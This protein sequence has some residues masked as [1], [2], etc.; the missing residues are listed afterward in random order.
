[1]IPRTWAEIL[2]NSAESIETLVKDIPWVRESLVNLYWEV[3]LSQAEAEALREGTL[4]E[5]KLAELYEVQ[6]AQRDALASELSE[7]AASQA[8]LWEAISASD[9]ES[10]TAQAEAAD[11]I[12]AIDEWDDTLVWNNG[13]DTIAR[14]ASGSWI[15][16]DVVTEIREDI[17]S[18]FDIIN[19]AEEH[20]LLWALLKG[21]F[22]VL[23][24]LGFNNPFDVKDEIVEAADT[25]VDDS[26]MRDE[27]GE[28]LQTAWE[29]PERLRTHPALQEKLNSLL[30][31][32]NIITAE[33][34][35]AIH[36]AANWGEIDISVIKWAL[37]VETYERLISGILEDSEMSLIIK[38][39]IISEVSESVMDAYPHIN[40]RPESRDQLQII[41]REHLWDNSAQQLA[42]DFLSWEKVG[43]W[44]LLASAPRYAL[45]ATWLMISLVASWVI[46]ISDIALDI[47][48]D[49]VNFTF[50]ATGLI[51][52]GISIP[53][54]DFTE[55]LEE[56]ENVERW[57][58]LAVMYRQSGPFVRLISNVMWWLTR[59]IIDWL[60]TNSLDINKWDLA[61]WNA[62]SKL[63]NFTKLSQAVS[64][65]EWAKIGDAVSNGV[66]VLRKNYQIQAIMESGE[67]IQNLTAQLNALDPDILG[68]NVATT[69]DDLRSIVK[70]K[71]LI[72]SEEVFD[73]SRHLSGYLPGI[74][75]AEDTLT[76]S[77]QNIAQYQKARVGRNTIAQIW[78][79]PSGLLDELR[80]AQRGERLV[81]EGLDQAGALNK[82]QQLK[83]LATEFPDVFRHTLGVFPE[84]AFLWLD[85]T[86]RDDDTSIL[87]SIRDSLI[88]MTGIIWPIKLV[89]SGGAQLKEWELQWY[90]FAAA[91]A[92]TVL[93]AMDAINVWRIASQ[94][95]WAANIT[96][97]IWKEVVLRPISNV[98]N[99]G[100]HIWKFWRWIWRVALGTGTIDWAS[101]SRSIR[102]AKIPK[103]W[104][105]AALAAAVVGWYYLGSELLSPDISEEYQAMIDAW[106]IDTEGNIINPEEVKT[107]ISELSR[108]EKTALAEIIVSSSLDGIIPIEWNL[109]ISVD[110]NTVIVNA[111][112]NL[113]GEWALSPEVR[114]YFA[115]LGLETRFIS[116]IV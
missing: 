108:R 65:V 35:Q 49:V 56:M 87:E 33:E 31:D 59:T 105:L 100:A 99:A 101:I 2:P 50:T 109:D 61:F 18:G 24:W 102:T 68:N 23:G 72:P 89:F 103:R 12:L 15:S 115:Q 83:K 90:N 7:V 46:S 82:M 54:N 43:F 80:V 42:S 70:Q 32:P 95:W 45:D 41:L 86:M 76:Q 91:G 71:I 52:P 60:N 17:D 92:G 96:T 107:M 20:K 104:K 40:L 9:A 55:K 6:T 116:H 112:N 36:E 78:N 25:I 44:E 57:V 67:D 85:I 39:I 97:R 110:D 73:L 75:Q 53:V 4:P 111:E 106:V 58:F 30:Q 34:L 94:G 48:E 37:S 26:I 79:Y 38:E 81:F 114:S 1:M 93:F 69:I 63:A 88:Y 27:V 10:M 11:L 19:F 14:I 13:N 21:F 62:D 77:M 51:I 22:A 84:I 113:T 3:I 8:T 28:A 74:T 5:A 66:E 16:T 64:W 29:I 47:W 98:V